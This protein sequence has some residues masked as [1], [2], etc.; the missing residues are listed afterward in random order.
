MDTTDAFVGLTCTGCGERHGATEHGRCPDCGGALDPAYDHDAVDADRESLASAESMWEF[1][2]LLPFVAETG[3]SAAEGGTPLVEAPSLAGELGVGRVVVKD[4][5]RNPTG[6]FH[7]RGMSLAVTAAVDRGVEPLAHAS[8]GNSGQSAAAYAGRADLRSY[9]FVPS[10]APFS[11]KAMINVHG[12]E[13]RV[14][15]G[16]YP[17]A[18]DALDELQTEWH[19]LQEF[20][21]PYRHEGAKTIAYELL[22][23]L[24]WNLPDAVV[25]PVGG[26]D[27]LVGVVKGLRDLRDLDLVDSLPPVYAAQASGCAPVAAAWERGV[28]EPEPWEHPDTICGELEIPDPA[29]GALALEA[30][31]ETGG[32]ALAIDDDDALESATVGIEGVGVEFSPAGGVAA[33]AAGTDRVGGTLPADATV[34]VVNPASGAKT[35]DVLRSHLMSKGI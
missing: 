26:G 8:P 5:G 20:T 21:T 3:V 17:E 10:R 4:E 33:A 25:L 15:G 13:M 29:G 16:R 31:D 2:D 12:G 6:T 18:V 32:G 28:D 23:D 9:A 14:A 19:S 35:P 7:D 27:L 30:L 1:G 11:N 22:A 24:D 34:A